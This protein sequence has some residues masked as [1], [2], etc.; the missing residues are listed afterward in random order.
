MGLL[1]ITHNPHLAEKLCTR[2]M[3]FEELVRRPDQNRAILP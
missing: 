1:I 3:P 2:I